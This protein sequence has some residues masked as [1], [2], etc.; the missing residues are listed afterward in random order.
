MNYKPDEATMIAYLYG[1]LGDTERRQVEEYLQHHPE[2]KNRMQDWSFTRSALAG[3]AD[4]E[5]IAPPIVLD[6]PKQVPLWRERPVRMS[7][8]IAA[9]LILFLV[10]ARLLGAS[11]TVSSGELRIGFGPVEKP[12]P[13]L[14]KD[15]VSAM[16]NTSLQG[17][18]QVLQAAW[19]DE[20]KAVEASIQQNLKVNSGK[21]DRLMQAASEASEDQVRKFVSQM[22][23]DNLKLMKDYMQLSASGQKEYIE[24]LLVDF[25]AYLQEQ[26]KQDLQMLQ[27]KV[28]K[29]EYNTDQFK[30]E[31]EQILTSLITNR[32]TSNQRKN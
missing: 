11:A 3:I 6:E 10:A 12:A 5:V 29:V 15:E 30:Q 20:R 31:T 17:N 23:N 4:K 18:N 24:S 14:T 22:Q 7:L 9:S 26:R 2:E 32:S 1:E 25:S 16:I 13:S 27:A 28:N 8:G 21:I 19:S